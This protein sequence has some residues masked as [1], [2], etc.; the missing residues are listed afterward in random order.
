MVTEMLSKSMETVSN[1]GL[2]LGGTEILKTLW[3]FIG[4]N[5][6]YGI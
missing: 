2:E 5:N 1:D 3:Y 4:I 6:Y